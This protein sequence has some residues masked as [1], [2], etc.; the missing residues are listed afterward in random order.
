[1]IE[2]EIAENKKI[3][4]TFFSSEKLNLESNAIFFVG[5]QKMPSNSNEYVCM[6]GSLKLAL[7]SF[8]SFS[9]VLDMILFENAEK[10]A[11]F[12]LFFFNILMAR[13]P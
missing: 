12:L 7:N 2:T 6:R 3:I 9:W 1:M 11:W 13:E 8:G 4:V 5:S 10:Y